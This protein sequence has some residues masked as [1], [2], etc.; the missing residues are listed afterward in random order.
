MNAEPQIVKQRSGYL[1]K[2]VDLAIGS[3]DRLSMA[4]DGSRV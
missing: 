4:Q 3:K 2:Q 1:P